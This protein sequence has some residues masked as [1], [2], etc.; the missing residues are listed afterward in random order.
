MLVIG[1]LISGI[2]TT[3]EIGAL[4]AV[5][6]ALV[7]VGVYREIDLVGLWHACA[8]AAADS[9]RVLIVIA[10]VGA[11]VW[12]VAS[13]GVGPS[14]AASLKAMNLGPTAIV[15]LIAVGLIIA[16][17]LIESIILLVVIVPI[18]VPAALAA[19]ADLIHLGVVVV[20]ACC[21][22]LIIPPAGILIYLTAAQAEAQVTRVVREL[23]PFTIALLLLLALII[24]YPPLVTWLPSAVGK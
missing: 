21:I 18:L 2:A 23:V 5:Y 20:L 8:E 13:I 15:G 22:G 19:G 11:F 24:V 14:L 6:A 9:A 1:G 7:T 4:A 16:G 12:I 10:V 3:S 17:T